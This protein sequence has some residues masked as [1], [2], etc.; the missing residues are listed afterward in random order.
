M[1]F[2][3]SGSA[4][5][6]AEAANMAIAQTPQST[7]ARIEALFYRAG[8]EP[9]RNIWRTWSHIRLNSPFLTVAVVYG[10]PTIPP[11]L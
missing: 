8:I 1:S 3:I 2:V 9:P 7:A 10:S 6:A 4:A 11:I 5:T